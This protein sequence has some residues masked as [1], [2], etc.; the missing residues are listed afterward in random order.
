MEKTSKQASEIIGQFGVGFY[1]AFMVAEKIVVESRSHHPGAEAALWQ[2][3]GGDS[4]EIGP[5]RR[6]ERGTRVTLH[7]N[8]DASEYLQESRLREIVRKHSNYISY[9]IYFGLEG[10]EA[11]NQSTALWR[12]TPRQVEQKDYD[13]F[14]RQL[15]LDFEAPLTQMHMAVDA[16][17]QMYALLYIPKDP[18]RS[19][20]SLRK[21]DGLKL[22]ARKVLIQEYST[23]L[24]PEYLRFVHGVVDSEDLPLNI[25]RE[26]I[27]SNRVMNQLRRLVTNKVLDTLST[28]AQEN[29][30]QYARFWQTYGRAIKQGVV[31]ETSEPERLHG[32]LRFHSLQRPGEW[33]SLADYKTACPPEQKHIYYLMGDDERSLQYSPHLDAARANQLDVLFLTDPLDAFLLSRLTT[34]DGFSL[35]N[36]AAANLKPR[37]PAAAPEVESPEQVGHHQK[38]V[39]LFRQ[40]LGE[41]VVDVR[42]TDRL[43]ESPVRLVDADGQPPA[44]LQRVYRLLNKDLPEIKKILE[45]NP[46]H[47]ILAR[48]ANPGIE[49]DRLDDAIEQLYENA[50]LIE[51]LHPDPAGMIQRLQRILEAS[52][53]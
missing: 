19:F 21:Q 1:S 41:R 17:V 40:R 11:I 9:P 35:Q 18:E 12:Q 5:G 13:E 47:P 49:Q 14:Y 39:E 43:V 3:F 22:Y 32:L 33:L 10:Q 52:L 42:I 23:D 45:I 37:Q 6:V 34:Y 36:I 31:I 24:L 8:E 27:Q 15:T 44:E 2:S 7:L 25:S 16:P 4:F 53:R 20:L 51:G 30:E 26:S 28:M 46:D 48:L 29:A 50:L 38:L